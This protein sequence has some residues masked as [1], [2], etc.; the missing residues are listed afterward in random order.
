MSEFH[1]A[2]GPDVNPVTITFNSVFNSWPNSCDPSQHEGEPK[3]SWAS[4]HDP[5]VGKQVK[6]II[7]Q[8]LEFHEAGDPNVNPDTTTLAGS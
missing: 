2:G 6:A 5:S 8:I 7:N 3:Q 1:E 4:S